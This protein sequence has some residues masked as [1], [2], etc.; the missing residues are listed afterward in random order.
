MVRIKPEDSGGSILPSVP[1]S[2]PPRFDPRHNGVFGAFLAIVISG[3]GALIV[4]PFIG[5]AGVLAGI[6]QAVQNLSAAIRTFLVEFIQAFFE[7]FVVATS[8]IGAPSSCEPVIKGTTQAE[9]W[10]VGA[11]IL[12]FVAA[13]VLTGIMAYV[14]ATGVSS[15]V[16]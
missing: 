13:T 2:L 4:T 3:I 9:I 11:G 5:L 15:I 14:V 6:A 10:L 12:G 16:Q 7:P 8:C 1:D